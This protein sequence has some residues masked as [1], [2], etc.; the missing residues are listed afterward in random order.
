MKRNPKDTY[1][2]IAL[3]FSERFGRPINKMTIYR[4][5]KAAPELK[6]LPTVAD[7]RIR[8]IS[9]HKLEFENELYQR[10]NDKLKLTPLAYEGIIEQ[11]MSLQNSENYQKIPEIKKMKFSL[12][13]WQHYKKNRTMRY[14]KICGNKKIYTNSEVEKE[15]ERLTSVFEKYAACSWARSWAWRWTSC[16]RAKELEAKKYHGLLQTLSTVQMSKTRKKKSEI[17]VLRFCVLTFPEKWPLIVTKPRIV[18]IFQNTKR[19]D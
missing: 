5:K 13:W 14:K 1:H 11:A 18:T 15:C 7:N 12:H 8:I 17:L 9:Q 2:K 4:I 10:I 16:R 19:N 3:I 6:Q